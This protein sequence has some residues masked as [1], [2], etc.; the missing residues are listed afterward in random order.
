MREIRDTL[1]CFFLAFNFLANILHITLLFGPERVSALM[2]HKGFLH[3]INFAI[4]IFAKVGWS[5]LFRSLFQICG[6][7]MSL[8]LYFIFIYITERSLC[9]GGRW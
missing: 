9:G 1:Q 8:P 6:V 5:V 4:D 7:K 2:K 3:D